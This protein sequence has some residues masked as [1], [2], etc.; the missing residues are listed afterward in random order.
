MESM[1]QC[2]KG[3]EC[4]LGRYMLAALRA[5]LLSFIMPRGASTVLGRVFGGGWRNPVK[6]VRTR[7]V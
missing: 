1:E 7:K 2:V 4:R 5:R 6:L 3:G